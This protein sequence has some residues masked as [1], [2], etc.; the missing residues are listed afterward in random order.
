VGQGLELVAV[1]AWL[2]LLHPHLL[3]LLLLLLC[4]STRNLTLLRLR[5]LL[6]R[7]GW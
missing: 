4:C 7:R 1:R 5:V 6:L 3:L 2:L